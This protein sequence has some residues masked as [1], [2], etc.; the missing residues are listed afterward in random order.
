MCIIRDGKF[1]MNTIGSY[2]SALILAAL[3]AAGY[4]IVPVEP[5]KEMMEGGRKELTRLRSTAVTTYRAML[6]AATKSA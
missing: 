6:D 5:T 2:N 1:E 4:A 3:A